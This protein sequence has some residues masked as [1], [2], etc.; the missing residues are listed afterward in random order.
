MGSTETS[1]VGLGRTI[2]TEVRKAALQL[3]ADKYEAVQG[4]DTSTTE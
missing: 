4:D 3:G 2:V 1:K